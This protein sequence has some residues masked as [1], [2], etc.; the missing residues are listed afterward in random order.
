MPNFYVFDE[1]YAFRADVKE[2]GSSRDKEALFSSAF[3]DWLACFPENYS[4]RRVVLMEGYPSDYYDRVAIFARYNLDVVVY[5][6]EGST[7]ELLSGRLDHFPHL[8]FTGIRG[9]ALAKYFCSLGVTSTC[10]LEHDGKITSECFA[11]IRHAI[12]TLDAGIV[13]EFGLDIDDT[14]L[15]TGEDEL[16]FFAKSQFFELI[17]L[18]KTRGR[19]Y[20]VSIITA[21]QTE[22]LAINHPG[23]VGNVVGQLR[24]FGVEVSD[25]DII[26]TQGSFDKGR[27][28]SER[29]KKPAKAVL[30][31]D[32]WECLDS[33]RRHQVVAVQVYPFVS[34]SA[35]QR[36]LLQD[37]IQPLVLEDFT[38]GSIS[39]SVATVWDKQRE[40]ADK[41]EA[42][43]FTPSR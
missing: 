24:A 37:L 17:S 5:T 39:T 36:R 23:F 25:A 31:D 35:P 15:M 4:G 18:C 14:V 20:R 28:F 38:V 26:F 1:N 13:T 33:A 12:L 16:S 8:H 11:E 21:R 40:R 3:L 7:F 34:L 2:L 29:L 32:N 22:D 10:Y 30:F 19:Q 42:L 27:I 9:S 6:W 43:D 41:E